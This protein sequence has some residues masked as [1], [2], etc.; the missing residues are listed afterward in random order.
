MKNKIHR[1]FFCGNES[2]DVSFVEYQDQ[3]WVWS[4]NSIKSCIDRASQKLVSKNISEYHKGEQCKHKPDTQ[5]VEG[6][7][8]SCFIDKEKV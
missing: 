6:F 7:C 4:C 2:E 3:E 8:N 5:C 1:C